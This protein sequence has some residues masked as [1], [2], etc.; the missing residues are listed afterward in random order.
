MSLAENKALVRK[1][2]EISNQGK[3]DQAFELFDPSC[4]F[5]MP[6]GDMTTMQERQMEN[7]L[8]A[9][10]PDL[11]LTIIDIIAEGDFVA[12]R[13]ELRGTHH[14]HFM[15]QAP[16]GKKIDLTNSNWARI[17][18]GKIMELWPTM[19]QLNLMQQLGLVPEQQQPNP[20]SGEDPK[21]FVGTFYELLNRQEFEACRELLTPDF[22]SHRTTGDISA[23]HLINGCRLLFTSFP[24]LK[25]TVENLMAEGDRVAFQEVCAGTHLGD[26]MGRPPTSKS[27]KVINTGIWKISN[28]KLAEAWP[29]LD[30]ANWNQQL[31]ANE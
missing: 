20:A 23:E 12:Y 19:D 9:A 5:H 24:D 1:V 25:V 15:G 3:L 11:S 13:L 16:T 2:Y 21:A 30:I 17:Q 6:M 31:E 14:G 18:D 29:T 4:V 28:G 26:F 7:M 10:F 22:V 27:F 8:W